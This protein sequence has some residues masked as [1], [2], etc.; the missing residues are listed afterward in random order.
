MIRLGTGIALF[1]F[2]I[3]LGIIGYI[4]YTDNKQFGYD[5]DSD[6]DTP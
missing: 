2:L 1:L 5:S 6:S 3:V 4:F